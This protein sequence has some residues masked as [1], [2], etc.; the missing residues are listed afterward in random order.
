[1]TQCIRAI[2]PAYLD[3]PNSIP[4]SIEITT[5]EMMSHFI[6][7][8]VQFPFLLIPP[9]KLKWFFIFKAVV[10]IVVSTAI[11]IYMTSIA[12][13]TGQIWNQPYEI[14]GSD[15]SWRIMSSISSIAGGWA[16]MAVNVSDF[17][18]FLAK[19]KGVYWQGLFLPAISLLIGIFGVICTSC[20]KVVYDEYIWDPLA[21]AS[22]WDGPAGRCG[23][24][25]VG[26]CWC[27]AQIG[28]NLSANCISAS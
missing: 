26:F 20:A 6:F 10:V 23:A 18:R 2:W 7:W 11:V 28:T 27:V 25:F 22:Q 21:L 13:G 24:F 12:G 5:Q 3:I 15:R 1:M 9:H 8:S 16:T 19:P 14:Q 17:T 4:P